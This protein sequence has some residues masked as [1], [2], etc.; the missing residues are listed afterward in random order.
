MCN[1]CVDDAWIFLAIAPKFQNCC[2]GFEC[3]HQEAPQV[4]FFRSLDSKMPV[5]QM[6]AKTANISVIQIWVDKTCQNK[7]TLWLQQKR[8]AKLCLLDRPCFTLYYVKMSWPLRLGWRNVADPL[9]LR[10][11]KRSMIHVHKGLL[12]MPWIYDD[13]MMIYV[14][15]WNYW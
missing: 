1:L 10:K 15:C 11:A 14:C 6:D 13:F 5:P 3:Y 9:T 8:D 4:R 7:P 12:S 2:L